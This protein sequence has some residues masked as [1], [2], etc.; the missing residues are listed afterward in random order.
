ME[1]GHYSNLEHF[2]LFDKYAVGNADSLGLNEVELEMLL[3]Y[4]QGSLTD[5]NEE[6]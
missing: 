6:R 5:I 3:D 4:W 1:F 2:K